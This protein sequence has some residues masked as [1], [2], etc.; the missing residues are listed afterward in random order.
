[1]VVLRIINL[2]VWAAMS[3]Y[4]ARGAWSALVG[5]DARRGDAMRSACFL[6]GLLIIGF[7]VLSLVAAENDVLRQVL[8]VGS[9]GIGA[10]ILVLGKAYG[11]GPRV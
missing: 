7:N 10:Y 8:L 4:M 1:M 2:I 6:T 11:R 3:A 5:S 9:I